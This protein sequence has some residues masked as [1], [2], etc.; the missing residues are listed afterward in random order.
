MLLNGGSSVTMALKFGQFYDSSWI[1]LFFRLIETYQS[2]C[3]ITSSFFFL[4]FLGGHSSFQSSCVFENSH[5]NLTD[6]C[7]QTIPCKM[8]QFMSESNCR[9]K[10][11]EI[12]FSIYYTFKK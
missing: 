12:F 6:K 11:V 4:V 1:L 5:Y 2:E 10:Y 8:A 7:I 3:R 9:Y